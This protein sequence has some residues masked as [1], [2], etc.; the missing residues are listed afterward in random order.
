[1]SRQDIVDTLDF[2]NKQL[3]NLEVKMD[4]N[5]MIKYLANK[6]YPIE[7][8]ISFSMR[9]LRKLYSAEI[10][11]SNQLTPLENMSIDEILELDT[12]RLMAA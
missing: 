3:N 5:E 8:L 2:I 6:N 12:A 4:K 9:T 7:D 10:E 1:M 11:L